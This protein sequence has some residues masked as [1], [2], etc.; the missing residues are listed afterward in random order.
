MPL[1]SHL[2]HPTPTS[3]LSRPSSLATLPLATPPPELPSTA[4]PLL[5]QCRRR[6]P[7]PPA[8]SWAMRAIHLVF[9][10]E[11]RLCFSPKGRRSQQQQRGKRFFKS[12]SS[13]HWQLTIKTLGPTVPLELHLVTDPHNSHCTWA[14]EGAYTARPTISLRVLSGFW[15][16]VTWPRG[17]AA[18]CS[19]LKIPLHSGAKVSGSPQAN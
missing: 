2:P 5:N 11:G 9:L 16:F 1:L 15:I 10:R 8:P 14:Q 17:N 13:F 7:P 3:V 6:P 18:C 4:S 19:C 12:P